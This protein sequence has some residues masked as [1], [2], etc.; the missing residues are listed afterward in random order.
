MNIE[1]YDLKSLAPAPKVVPITIKIRKTG[2]ISFPNHTAEALGLKPGEK[3]KIIR[4]LDA[5]SEWFVAVTV[6]DNA[7][8]LCQNKGYIYI[9][10][11]ILAAHLIKNM[12]KNTNVE[13]P[14]LTMRIVK[15]PIEIDRFKKCHA[16]LVTSQTEFI[17]K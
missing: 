7:Y 4:N 11:K 1:V 15:E 14:S 16:I 8:V 2:I 10:N 13:P 5:P 12:S 9:A 6:D 3:I 17:K